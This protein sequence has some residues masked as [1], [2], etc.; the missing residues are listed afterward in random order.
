MIPSTDPDLYRVLRQL[1]MP[2]NCSKFVLT[3]EVDSP[4][5]IEATFWPGGVVDAEE[6]VT[7]R[8]Y[9]TDQCDHKHWEF[10]KHGRCCTCGELMADLGD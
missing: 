7:R 4:V 1:G 3:V 8:F 2:D 9:L 10:G 6:P 5:K